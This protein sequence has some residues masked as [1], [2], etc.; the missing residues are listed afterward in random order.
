MKYLTTRSFNF[1]ALFLTILFLSQID[2]TSAQTVSNQ[3][4]WMKKEW[5]EPEQPFQNLRLQIEKVFQKKSQKNWRSFIT[6]LKSDADK[7]P[8]SK[9]ALFKWAY[10]SFLYSAETGI[11]DFQTF[12]RLQSL[13][14]ENFSSGSYQMACLR[15]LIESRM[16]ASPRLLPIGERLFRRDSRDYDVGYLL[17]NMFN[18]RN[19]LQKPQAIRVA[20]QLVKLS[21]TRRSAQSSLGWVYFRI[22]LDTHN[23]KDSAT[24]I[25]AYRRYLQLAPTNDPFRKRAQD[26]IK[27]MQKR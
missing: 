18:V 22:W 1:V 10:A 7:S 13:L 14:S 6:R 16:F 19:A 4:S 11:T 24:S 5:I 3:D 27:E 2:R 17:I 20:R 15:F 12:A 25:A 8:Q 9:T 26:L 21:P 23:P